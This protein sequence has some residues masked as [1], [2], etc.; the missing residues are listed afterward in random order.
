VEANRYLTNEEQDRFLSDRDER[1]KLKAEIEE[2]IGIGTP[3]QCYVG[4]PPLELNIVNRVA[5]EDGIRHWC[6]AIGDFNPLYRSRDYASK[7]I[8][9][10]LVAPPSFVGAVILLFE[11]GHSAVYKAGYNVSLYDAGSRIE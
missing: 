11:V 8:Y 2:K 10:G 1:E 5:T 6:D 3:Q 9:G 7:S 4:A